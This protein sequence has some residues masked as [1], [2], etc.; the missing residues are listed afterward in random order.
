MAAR[1]PA[2][3]VA[4]AAND[5]FLI[6][7]AARDRYE[8]LSAGVADDFG[9]EILDGTAHTLD[10]LEAVVDRFTSAVQTLPMFGDRK[11]VWLRDISFYS[12]HKHLTTDNAKAVVERFHQVLGGLDPAQ[13]AVVLSACPVDR[14]RREYK[15]LQENGELRWLGTDARDSAANLAELLQAEATAGEVRFG[16]G[17]EELLLARVGGDPRMAVAETAKLATYAGRGGTIDDTMVLELV[18]PFGNIEFFEAVE[19]F[20]TLDLDRA[21]EGQRKH[22]FAGQDAR[23]LLSALQNRNRILYQLRALMDSGEITASVNKAAF[24][25]AAAK[26]GPLFAN[27]GAKSAFNL[28]GQNSFYL[29]RLAPIASKLTLKR[30]IDFQLDFIRAFSELIDRPTEPQAVLRE[31]TVRCLGTV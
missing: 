28:F 25:R 4:F 19:A 26:H 9:R 8:Q 12:D 16:A 3:F 11:V 10:D 13:V 21:L 18:P 23:P 30:L 15:W 6:N 14:R 1:P 31:M 24:E 22:F 29:S 17:V 27:P 7:R 2:P 20:Y 5:D